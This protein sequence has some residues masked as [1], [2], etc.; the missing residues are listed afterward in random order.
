MR[1]V[2]GGYAN[3]ATEAATASANSTI[4]GSVV[5][6]GGENCRA[7]QAR[8]RVSW[9]R[10]R[11]VLGDP[12]Q[13][14]AALLEPL[15]VE[16]DAG[17]EAGAAHLGDAVEAGERSEQPRQRRLELGDAVDQPL[18]LDEVEVGERGRA[19]GRVAG[20]GVSRA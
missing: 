3:A 9:P 5:M 7:P 19:G 1:P 13:G 10:S 14:D 16:L 11:E 2:D 17:E 4:W 6:K 20:V 12:G 18:G 8:R 15:A